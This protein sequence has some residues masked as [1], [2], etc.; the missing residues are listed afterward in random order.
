VISDQQ[1]EIDKFK[2]SIKKK[3]DCST[4]TV[5]TKLNGHQQSVPEDIIT[6]RKA[7]LMVEIES[8]RRRLSK[9]EKR[10]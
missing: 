2:T 3:V 8:L 4:Q 9:M 6:D 10:I 1:L 5:E 7:D